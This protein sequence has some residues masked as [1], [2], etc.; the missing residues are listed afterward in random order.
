MPKRAGIADTE[1]SHR[2]PDPQGPQ[3]LA[4]PTL[5]HRV[6]TSPV[7]AVPPSDQ[8]IDD[9]S[10]E[11]CDGRVDAG[12]VARQVGRDVGAGQLRSEPAGNVDSGVSHPA[13]MSS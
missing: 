12:Q 2:A 5:P 1:P 8:K 7:S 3:H 6:R 11:V 10:A 13:A 4:G 9:K